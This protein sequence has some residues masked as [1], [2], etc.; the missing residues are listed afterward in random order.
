[1][2]KITFEKPGNFL[3]P[4][5][6]VMVSCRSGKGESN[7][8]TVAWTGTVCSEPPMLSISVRK[9]RH[10]F[11]MIHETGEFV[12]NL[13]DEALL[14]ACDYCGCVSGAKVDKFRECGLTEAEA[15]FVKAPLIAEAPVNIECRVTKELE[16]GSHVMFLAEVLCVHVDGKYLDENNAF[17]ME[18]VDLVAYS[19]GKYHGLGEILGT[20][21]FSVRKK[22]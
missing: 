6:A 1:M 15:K 4:V 17:H 12:V 16:L 9:E 22:K 11:P 2:N 3:Y 13:T 18:Q 10:S 8:I 7:I 21:G 19:H 20:F 5:P 14:R